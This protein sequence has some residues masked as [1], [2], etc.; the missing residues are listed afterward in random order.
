MLKYTATKPTQAKCGW[1]TPVAS[2]PGR[3]AG[4]QVRCLKL[5]LSTHPVSKQSRQNH[6]RPSMV[7]HTINP[8][9]Q[10]SEAG[11]SLAEAG[12]H[13]LHSKFQVSQSYILRPWLKT[14]KDAEAGGSLQFQN[15]SGPHGGGV[16][17]KH[18]HTLRKRGRED[19]QFE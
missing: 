3:Q 8:S 4:R 14:T 1:C 19:F 6:V 10:D 17:S 2:A 13:D 18:T 12:Q 11:G 5:S 9:I 15:Q 16:F 7:V